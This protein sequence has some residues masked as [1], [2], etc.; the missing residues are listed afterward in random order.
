MDSFIFFIDSYVIVFSLCF[1][2]ESCYFDVVYPNTFMLFFTMVKSSWSKLHILIIWLHL[3]LNPW[4]LA[5]QYSGL[6]CDA[7]DLLLH[8]KSVYL[9]PCCKH[10]MNRSLCHF[11]RI[12]KYRFQVQLYITKNLYLNRYLLHAR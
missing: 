4:E 3:L 12:S 6:R 2:K 10:K 8:K 9:P 5:E 1:I 11:S 7:H